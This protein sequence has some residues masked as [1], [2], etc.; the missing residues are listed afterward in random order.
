MNDQDF[1]KFVELMDDMADYYSRDP[2]SE[3]ANKL[4]FNALATRT[5][6]QVQYALS[7]HMRDPESGRF[8][9]RAADVEK[10]LTGEK[11]TTDKIIAMARGPRTPLG[12]FCRMQIGSYDLNNNSDMFYLRQ[13]AE[14]CLQALPEWET[15]AQQG[16]YSQHE[17]D[18][19]IEHNVA[20]DQPF[21]EG[22]PIP[23]NADEI[24][25]KAN[26]CLAERKR[27]KQLQLSAPALTEEQRQENKEKMSQLFK[28]LTQ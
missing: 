28:E 26:M 13:R 18:R 22:L 27:E 12:V 15:R 3:S 24:Q 8:M 11:L 20:V 2:M 9:P 10:H 21:R 1:E 16:Q 14:E 7:C 19:M 17:V 4:F 6:E 5:L 23:F 25:R